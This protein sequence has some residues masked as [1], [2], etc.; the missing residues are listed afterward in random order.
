[1]QSW[2]KCCNKKLLRIFRNKR[3]AYYIWCVKALL[4]LITLFAAETL[5]AQLAI[6]GRVINQNTT[7]PLAGASIFLNNTSIGTVVGADGQFSLTNIPAGT[8]ELIVSNVGY[9]TNSYIFKTEQLPLKL[10][11]KMEIKEQELENITVGGYEKVT[12]AEWGQTFLYVFLGSTKNAS[13]CELL[14][15]DAVSLRYYKKGARLTAVADEPLMVHNK[16]L[17]YVIEYRLEDFEVNF[18]TKVNYFAGYTLFK[19]SRKEIKKSQVKQRQITYHGSMMHFMRSVY[20]NNMASNGF[21]VTRMKR[22]YNEEKLRVRALYRQQGALYGD[23]SLAGKQ[24]LVQLA[25]YLQDSSE[26][27]NTV[28][29]EKDFEDV[30]AQYSVTSDSIVKASD[31]AY[32]KLGWDDFIAITHMNSYEE[33][34]YLSHLRQNRKPGR[35]ASLLQLRN[36]NFIWLQ[37]NGNW[38]PPQNIV[39]S[40]YWAWSEK[41]ANMLPLDYEPEK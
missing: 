14:N 32:Y 12:W 8:Y 38:S 17:G 27:F 24:K 36:G 10:L 1:M 41:V 37:S 22:I 25:K 15:K 11:F 18:N 33:Y 40:G 3:I 39:S 16:A 4:F 21:V 29:N 5:T 2:R 28:L 31:D 19:E 34:G 23:T 35:P 13:R 20:N 30:Y 9:E 26:Y 6:T 7:M